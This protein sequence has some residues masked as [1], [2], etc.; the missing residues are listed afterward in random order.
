MVCRVVVVLHRSYGCHVTL[1]ATWPLYLG[2]RRGW[3]KGIGTYLNEHD[4]DDASSLSGRCGTSA[5]SSP[6][7][8][9]CTGSVTWHWE[10]VGVVVR[11]CCEG[12]GRLVVVVAVGESGEAAGP[13]GIDGGGGWYGTV[14]G[15]LLIVDDNKSSVGVHRRSLWV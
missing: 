7:S 8:T 14:V 9:G 6:L 5:T 1:L 3:R 2:V 10:A 13:V 12:S 11:V 4:G 15:C